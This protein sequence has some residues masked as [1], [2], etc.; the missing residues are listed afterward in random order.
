MN[1]AVIDSA[2]N[3]IS[4]SIRNA[5]LSILDTLN[6]P[7]K[8]ASAPSM[9]RTEAAYTAGDKVYWSGSIYSGP[10]TVLGVADDGQL[11]IQPD[12]GGKVIKLDAR[13]I[14]SGRLTK[15]AKWAVGDSV[16]W[17]GQKYR[18]D[19]QI[20]EVGDGFVRIKPTAGTKQ[21]RIDGD[22]VDSDHSGVI[23]LD[24]QDLASGGLTLV[25]PTLADALR[26]V[27]APTD[28]DTALADDILGALVEGDI[29][30]W[31]GARFQVA[32][33]VLEVGDDFLRITPSIKITDG[34]IA[35]D[36][37]VIR[38]NLADLNSG[39]LQF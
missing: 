38:L 25:L 34:E 16:R 4:Q 17:S 10:A 26:D 11:R 32:G 14:M 20:T 22:W 29:V 6:P 1:Q 3:S 7:A 39:N 19:G 9:V 27:F 2:V 12:G 8:P 37:K 23:R 15:A 30:V 18:C 31:K 35:T 13:D 24:R 33:T 21:V 36:G 28:T 5:F